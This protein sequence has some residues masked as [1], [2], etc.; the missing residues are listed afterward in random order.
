MNVDVRKLV[1][2]RLEIDLH[3]IGVKSL[4]FRIKL[5]TTIMK[6]A[7]RLFC[8]NVTISYEGKHK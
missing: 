4:T 5:A 7:C 3:V 8:T 1:N 6:W 2:D